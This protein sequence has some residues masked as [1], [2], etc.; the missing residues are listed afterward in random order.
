MKTHVSYLVLL[1]SSFLVR[2]D[3]QSI[4]DALYSERFDPKDTVVLE[5]EPVLLPLSEK[6]AWIL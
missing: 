4:L 1:A 3:D 5:Q 6:E 2:S